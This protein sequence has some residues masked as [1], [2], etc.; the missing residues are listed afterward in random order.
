MFLAIV[1]LVVLSVALVAYA[2]ELISQQTHKANLADG[3]MFMGDIH[4]KQEYKFLR[5]KDFPGITMRFLRSV[6]VIDQY[7]N[8]R[9]YLGKQ[10]IF[11]QG[12]CN[13]IFRRR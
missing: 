13:S 5:V 12:W 8:D 7:H 11:Y 10:N 9:G 1:L 6:G 2:L 3:D 4:H